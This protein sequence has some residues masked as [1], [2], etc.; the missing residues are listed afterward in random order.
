MAPP[1]RQK[2]GAKVSYGPPQKP[3]LFYIFLYHWKWSLMSKNQR[4]WLKIVIKNLKKSKIFQF[5][6]KST[7][8]SKNEQYFQIISYYYRK[9]VNIL[10]MLYSIALS[11]NAKDKK[12]RL[13]VFKKWKCAFQPMD[14]FRYGLISCLLQISPY[15]K[16]H[17]LNPINTGFGSVWSPSQLWKTSFLHWFFG[18]EWWFRNRGRVVPGFVE[19]NILLKNYFNSN[20]VFKFDFC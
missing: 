17:M 7:H 3:N 1:K 18:F 15:L 14:N 13:K 9:I 2:G 12:W 8:N 4:K 11:E 19:K 16:L 5:F 20:S 6:L 10:K